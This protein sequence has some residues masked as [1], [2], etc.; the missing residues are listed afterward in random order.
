MPC[1][2]K[3]TLPVS[4]L[5]ISVFRP[6]Y[7]KVLSSSTFLILEIDRIATGL[8]SV[9]NSEEITPTFKFNVESHPSIFRFERCFLDLRQ[10]LRRASEHPKQKAR[11]ASP[12]TPTETLPPPETHTTPPQ[13]LQGNDV[14][15]SP[16]STLSNRSAKAEHYTHTFANNF[17]GA[18]LLSLERHLNNSVAWYDDDM[19]IIPL[20]PLSFVR[21]TNSKVRA[22]DADTTWR[23]QS[24][25]Q[26]RWRPVILSDT[27]ILA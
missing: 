26:K 22:G 7:D 6:S 11:S 2:S 20:Y 24:N 19:G 10:I 12:Q 13:Q 3:R 8:A 27:C 17:L 5:I 1:I 14:F 16:A 23:N 4:H 9:N 18:T 21:A 15:N 25:R